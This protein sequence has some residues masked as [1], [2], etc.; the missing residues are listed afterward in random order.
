MGTILEIDLT[1]KKYEVKT[2]D[3]DLEDRYIGGAGVAAAIYAKIV[4][5][6]IDPFD[7][8]NPLIFSAGPFTGTMVPF[9]GR[10][11]VISRRTAPCR[12]ELKRYLSGFSDQ[13]QGWSGEASGPDGMEVEA[14]DCLRP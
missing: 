13:F 5:P 6:E 1:T 7:A 8:N 10:H 9:C 11:F 12:K 4:D 2:V 3:P 14:F